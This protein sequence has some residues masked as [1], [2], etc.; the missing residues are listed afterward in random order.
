MRAIWI[1]LLLLV[2]SICGCSRDGDI[3]NTQTGT[4]SFSDIA[5]EVAN[6]LITSKSE[7]S[8]AYTVDIVNS[9]MEVVQSYTNID[10]PSEVTLPIGTYTV[11]GYTASSVSGA[12]FD[13][14]VY[15]DSQS[16]TIEPNTEAS[17]SLVCKLQSIKVNILF[18]DK[19]KSSFTDYSVTVSNGAGDY[20][21]FDE[22]TESNY[23]YITADGTLT[24]Y[25]AM[26]SETNGV[27]ENYSATK[28]YTE[29][30]ANDFLQLTY[31][32]EDKPEADNSSILLSVDESLN[33]IESTY[34]LVIEPSDLLIYGNDFDIDHEQTLRAGVAAT[35]EIDVTSDDPITSL[36]ISQNM[37]MLLALGIPKSADLRDSDTAA[38]LEAL[39]ITTSWGSDYCSA[40]IYLTSLL[41][42]LSLTQET[43]TIAFEATNSAGDITYKRFNYI[44]IDAVMSTLA[45][46][47]DA[48]YIWNSEGYGRTSATLNG[49][50]YSV[51]TPTNMKF[52][53]IGSSDAEWTD[54]TE[55]LVV[56]DV[57][58]TISVRVED[59]LKL[60][61]TYRYKLTADGEDGGEVSFATAWPSIPNMG[62]DNWYKSDGIWYPSSSSSDTY[63]S[64]GND[65]VDM[66]GKSSNST[67]DTE[68]MV[69]GSSSAKLLTYDGVTM[70]GLAA[71]NIFVGDFAMS[72]WTADID[73][74]RAYTGRP[75]RMT[76]YY[77]YHTS[78][79]NTNA[80]SGD[81]YD[82]CHI[83]ISLENWGTAT[84]RP[85][86]PTV[87]GYG[88]LLHNET[89]EDFEK[90]TIDIN[91]T[92]TSQ[93]T[94]IVV[95]A[96]SSRYGEDYRGGGGSTLWIDEFNFEFD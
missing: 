48:S 87:I 51:D 63:W 77:C 96:T 8:Q 15:A 18:S 59:A 83:Y 37:D 12:I 35:I 36:T 95:V 9:S 31:D 17:V 20:L 11:K 3:Y 47:P 92:S 62:F 46:E 43:Q 81:T 30:V 79:I 27:V 89:M 34:E 21:L 88:E 71:G 86:S 4:L 14:P 42:K 54:V 85:S 61:T 84:S 2:V 32:V 65:G 16:V 94:H 40:K 41:G 56:D 49:E 72:G 53:Y 45:A 74:G 50:W 76:G 82:Y 38:V 24:C 60:N 23:G 78:W 7:E 39:G 28:V 91:Y 57:N 26:T 80:E 70:V 1:Y 44:V 67:P 33:L 93:P 10:L 25:V 66:S 13:E 64:T 73:F 68:F 5:V 19:V 29:L 6:N 58:N 55:G 75:N 69:S 22:T 90:F 52:S